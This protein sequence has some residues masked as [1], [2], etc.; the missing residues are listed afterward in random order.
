[1]DGTDLL[2]GT[3]QTVYVLAQLEGAE[4]GGVRILD[5]QCVAPRRCEVPSAFPKRAPDP[6]INDADPIALLRKPLPQLLG[7]EVRRNDYPIRASDHLRNGVLVS[8]DGLGAGLRHFDEGQVVDRDHTGRF[9]QRRKDE[10]GSPENID[11]AAKEL[12]RRPLRPRPDEVRD[13][14]REAVACNTDAR[15]FGHRIAHPSAAAKAYGKQDDLDPLVDP[16][17]GFDDRGGR[18][19]DA[20]PR[21]DQ[22]R[23]LDAD[24][25]KSFRARSSNKIPEPMR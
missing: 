15:M 24:D 4:E 12:G 8:E 5:A 9:H 7:G 1:V 18:M 14:C 16:N 2:E 13:F 25:Q 3:K 22:A 20:G 19:T 23:G 17:E 6:G 11:R 21:S 10:V